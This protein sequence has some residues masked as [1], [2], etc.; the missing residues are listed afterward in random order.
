M[1]WIGLGLVYGL[2]MRC[3]G[4]QMG[5]DGMGWGGFCSFSALQAARIDARPDGIVWLRC[6][7]GA[8]EAQLPGSLQVASR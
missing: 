7:L 2:G 1:G 4:M 8:A 3:D 6:R 5:W